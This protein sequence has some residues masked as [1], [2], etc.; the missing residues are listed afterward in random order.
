MKLFFTILML[1]NLYV[2]SSQSMVC[3]AE[4]YSGTKVS[5]LFGHNGIYPTQG[6][7]TDLLIT[8]ND[9]IAGR[10]SKNRLILNTNHDQLKL[11]TFHGLPSLDLMF[12]ENAEREDRLSRMIIV[13]PNGVRYSFKDVGCKF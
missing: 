11:K 3:D 13:L 6:A 4:T 7:M 2:E 10:I 12:A 8:V 5:I 9:G 1:S